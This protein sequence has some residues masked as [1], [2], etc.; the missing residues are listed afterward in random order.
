MGFFKRRVEI[1]KEFQRVNRDDV[2]DSCPDYSDLINEI[3]H[4]IN[5]SRWELGIQSFTI[6]P[7]NGSR[8]LKE[9]VRKFGNDNLEINRRITQETKTIRTMDVGYKLLVYFEKQVFRI[10]LSSY[11]TVAKENSYMT[12]IYDNQLQDLCNITCMGYLKKNYPYIFSLFLKCIEIPSIE[13]FQKKLRSAIRYKINES[14]NCY[15]K[16]V[17]LVCKNSIDVS[18]SKN[19][20]PIGELIGKKI[21]DMTD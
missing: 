1:P 12:S 10:E 9:M 5:A 15:I 4:F 18:L 13:T 19:D 8:R 11:A 21:I 14:I 3:T 17:S 7:V 16:G 6:V 20:V 2:R